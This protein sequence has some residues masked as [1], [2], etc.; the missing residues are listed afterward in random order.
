MKISVI[1]FSLTGLSLAE[2][3]EDGL[4][5]HNEVDVYVKSIH[6]DN[7]IKESLNQWAEARF[8]DSDALIFVCFC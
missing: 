6:A 8:Q 4:S 1:A 5:G 7:S 2:K 3:L